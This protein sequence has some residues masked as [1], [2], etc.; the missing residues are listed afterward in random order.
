[1]RHTAHGT[2]HTAHGTRHTAHGTRH[3]AHGTRHTAHG[4]QSVKTI[5]C[6]YVAM[7]QFHALI[8]EG[9]GAGRAGLCLAE[10]DRAT[11]AESKGC[12]ASVP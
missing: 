7:P 3:T 9:G 2:R 12:V 8:R 11:S 5:G 1:T 10:I 4:T 6:P